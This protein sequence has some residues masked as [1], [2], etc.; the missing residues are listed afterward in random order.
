[1]FYT[2][3]AGDIL[4]NSR[5]YYTI[6][7][8][9]MQPN[10]TFLKSSELYMKTEEYTVLC[11]HAALRPRPRPGWYLRGCYLQKFLFFFSTF[12]LFLLPL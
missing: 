3:G 11:F 12:C 5:I 8:V 9:W 6:Y 1:M 2:Q 4:L 10:T 7:L